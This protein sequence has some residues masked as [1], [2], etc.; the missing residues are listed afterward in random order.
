MTWANRLDDALLD[1][2]QMSITLGNLALALQDT[3]D[4]RFIKIVKFVAG[5]VKR[6]Q[7]QISDAIGQNIGENAA[8]L[9]EQI[10]AMSKLSNAFKEFRRVCIEEIDDQTAMQGDRV[11]MTKRVLH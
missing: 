8:L 11:E 7:Q 4:Q 9:Q 5:R 6:A 3:N 10:D 1:L 2:D